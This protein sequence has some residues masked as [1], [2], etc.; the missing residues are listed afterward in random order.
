MIFGGCTGFVIALIMFLVKFFK[1]RII[2]WHI[3]ILLCA[4]V[5][6]LL[7]S[8]FYFANDMGKCFE[9]SADSYENYISMYICIC[10]C[11]VNMAVKL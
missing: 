10:V 6:N 1:G 2:F 4:G 8:C 3:P 7:A 5:S 9:A 11:G